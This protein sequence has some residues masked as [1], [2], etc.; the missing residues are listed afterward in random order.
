MNYPNEIGSPN[1]SLSPQLQAFMRD[2]RDTR[3]SD[4]APA[5]T[6]GKPEPPA[7]V[8][9]DVWQA[10]EQLKEQNCEMMHE[11]NAIKQENYVMKRDIVLLNDSVRDLTHEIIALRETLVG[12][13]RTPAVSGTFPPVTEIQAATVQV[14]HNTDLTPA[15]RRG[16]KREWAVKVECTHMS[17]RQPGVSVG[18]EKRDVL[19]KIMRE[20]NA[21][22]YLLR[23][24][25]TSMPDSMLGGVVRRKAM[26]GVTRSYVPDQMIFLDGHDQG[27]NAVRVL[28]CIGEGMNLIEGFGP[29][30]GE[31]A[32]RSL[33]VK[34]ARF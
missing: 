16:G 24:V 27:M 10:I 32:N 14:F 1:G 25:E 2:M 34:N 26:P 3:N 33:W 29:S 17:K 5:T 8:A 9:I 11:Y 22:A 31:G 23:F 19:L 12:L 28:I 21:P 6:P 4:A 30:N 15:D 13:L 20:K 18:M 7:T